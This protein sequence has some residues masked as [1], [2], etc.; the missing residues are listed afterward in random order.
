MRHF[1]SRLEVAEFVAVTD[2]ERLRDLVR[3]LDILV[4]RKPVKDFSLADRQVIIALRRWRAYFR[5]VVGL[6]I[7]KHSSPGA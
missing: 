6:K 4:A 1:A 3:G 5:T 7:Q 2:V